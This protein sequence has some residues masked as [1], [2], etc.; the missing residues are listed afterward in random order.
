[1]TPAED[2]HTRYAAALRTY[3]AESTEASPAD[4]RSS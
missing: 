3:L 4:A 2:F 1:M